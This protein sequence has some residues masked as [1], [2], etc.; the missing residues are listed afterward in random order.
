MDELLGMFGSI[1]EEESI[2]EII[3][4]FAKIIAQLIEIIKNFF[5]GNLG[6]EEEA[7]DGTTAAAAE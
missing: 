4:M 1:G 3:N 7:A 2:P 5:S 6:A